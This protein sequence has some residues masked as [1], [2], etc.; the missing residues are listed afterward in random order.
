MLH[1]QF[2]K[3]SHTT[4]TLSASLPKITPKNRMIY[5]EY[6]YMKRVLFTIFLWRNPGNQ[7]N[8][9]RPRYNS[10]IKTNF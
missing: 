10:K 6:K 4:G 3:P 8:R 2:G 1:P 9:G 5:N 7:G